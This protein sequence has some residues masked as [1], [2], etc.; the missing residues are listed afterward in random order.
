MASVFSR[1]RQALGFAGW[2]GLCLATSAA[3]ALASVQA[4]AFY[5]SLVRP[6]WAP[7]AWL[8]GPVWSALFLCMAIA[9]WLVWRAPPGGPGRLLALALFLAQL[10]ANAAWSWLFFAWR[11]GGAAFADIVLLWLL[12]AATL[13]AFWRRSPIAG[14]LLLPYLLWVGFAA[15]LNWSLWQANPQVLG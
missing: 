8:F 13:I 11:L 6:P 9:A 15:A 4:G 12:I 7:P 14:L 3:G 1:Q 5:A 2:L 10:V